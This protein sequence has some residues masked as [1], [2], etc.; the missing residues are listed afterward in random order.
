M[1]T[2]VG[3]A[4]AFFRGEWLEPGQ[5]DYEA[6]RPVFNHRFEGRPE[7]IARCAGVADVIAAVRRARARGLRIEVRS[8]GWN[9]GVSAGDGMMIDLSP[10]RGVRVSPERRTA[11]IEGGVRGGDLQIEAGLHGLAAVTGV[12]SASGVGLLLG[13]GLGY[14]AS[15]VG[16]ASESIVAIELVTAEGE[17][18]I[19]S[20]DE[21]EDLFWAVRGT[22]GSYGVVTA[23]EVRLHEVPP[24]VRSGA[25]TWSMDAFPE[26]ARALRTLPDWA[27]ENLSLVSL[28][29]S[30]ALEGRGGYEML[31]CHSG[32]PEHARAEFDRLCAF[33]SPVEAAVTELPFRDLHF[34]NDGL[35]APSRVLIDEQPVTALDDELIATLIRR[36]REPGGDAMRAIEITPRVGAFGRHPE[37]PSA[38]REGPEPPIW[39]IGPGAWWEDE[40]EDEGHA[41]WT[42]AVMADIRR[43]GPAEGGMH[44]NSIGVKVDLEGLARM[45]GDR[46]PRLRELKRRW[47]PDNIFAGNHGI[48]P[49]ES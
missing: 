9:I 29:N 26:V 8:T 20:P 17:V 35:F 24:V 2:L 31:A 41:R 12:L 39:S 5:R 27:S 43:M 44:P 21:N 33:A 34:V 42:A 28:L 13:G 15:R 49:A 22:T 11:R 38:M 30:S 7:V 16:W 23:L 45:Y 14:L 10:M 4:P 46:L 25:F 37:F 36:I 32:P 19:A 48:P 3:N 40:S 47:D 6:A 1:D 18:V